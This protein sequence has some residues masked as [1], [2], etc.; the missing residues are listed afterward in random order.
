[1][2][3]DKLIFYNNLGFNCEI[4]FNL[5]ILNSPKLAKSMV[6]TKD[7]K[8]II[9]AFEKNICIINVSDVITNIPTKTKPKPIVPRYVSIGSEKIIYSIET[10]KNKS[11]DPNKNKETNN[12]LYINL[13]TSILLWTINDEHNY[14]QKKIMIKNNI[15]TLVW[16]MRN[17]I[18]T[19]PLQLSQLK[20]P[21]P[22]RTSPR[23]SSTPS[24]TSSPATSAL[25]LPALPSTSA[26]P[27]TPART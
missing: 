15:K 18:V 12:I 6:I 19:P 17:I 22:S 10:N 3:E 27:S 13:G 7:N 25:P 2:S 1:M 4:I 26:L 8:Y 24:R 16:G 5:N 20:K 23:T 14:N 11:D 9:I 21:S